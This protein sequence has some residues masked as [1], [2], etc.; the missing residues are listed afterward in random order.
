VARSAADRALSDFEKGL[1][2]YARK[3]KRRAAGR[4]CGTCRYYIRGLCI[5]QDID[6][7]NESAVACK[8]HEEK[9]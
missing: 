4:K 1:R 3:L 5:E 7:N 6:V 8:R 2:L 9:R